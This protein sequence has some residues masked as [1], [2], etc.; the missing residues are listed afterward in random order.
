MEIL[1][2]QNVKKEGQEHEK[3]GQQM[4]FIIC[5]WIILWSSAIDP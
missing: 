3:E 5:L 4:T 2:L 1:G